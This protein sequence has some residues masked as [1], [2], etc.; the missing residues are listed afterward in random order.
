MV[1]SFAP[2]LSE[3]EKVVEEMKEE[4]EFRYVQ[5]SYE[6]FEQMTDRAL[7]VKFPLKE[8]VDEKEWKKSS[9]KAWIPLTQLRVAGGVL[10]FSNWICQQKG[11]ET[12]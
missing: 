7:L 5:L 2:K 3:V 1:K 9:G 4:E 8:F 12:K 11:L 10:Y 6:S